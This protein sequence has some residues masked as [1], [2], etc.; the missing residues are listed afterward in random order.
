[1]YI[2]SR[3]FLEVI[4]LPFGEL[5]ISSCRSASVSRVKCCISSW[6]RTCSMEVFYTRQL[7]RCPDLRNLLRST[8]QHCLLECDRCHLNFIKRRSPLS[9][10]WKFTDPDPCWLPWSRPIVE[11]WLLDSLLSQALFSS[12]CSGRFRIRN[13]FWSTLHGAEG[14]VRKCDSLS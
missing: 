5:W 14:S 12:L 3:T 13:N 11:S 8:I 4:H 7:V 10:T 9:K 1:M 2:V 6:P